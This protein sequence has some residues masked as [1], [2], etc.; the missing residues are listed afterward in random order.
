MAGAERPPRPPSGER[1]TWAVAPDAA[2]VRLDVFLHERFPEVSRS[3]LKRWVEEGR[4]TID[5]RNPKPS[6]MLR[7]GES[8]TMTVPP[9]PPPMPIPQDIPFEIIH[10]D[11]SLLIIHKPAGL[12]VHP[13]AGNESGGTLVNALLSRTERLSREAGDFRPGIVHRLDRE[14][15][16]V[17]VIARDDDAHR[18][19]AAQFKARMVRKEYLALAHDA[20]ATPEGRIDA[21]LGR[22]P[23]DRRR[24]IVR[25][26]SDGKPALTSWRAVGTIGPFAWFRCFPHTGRT[27]QIRVHLKSIGHPIACDHLYG[28]EKKLTLT[29]AHGRKV[30]GAEEPVL[31]RHALHAF[32][33]AFRHPVDGRPV[34]FEAPLPPDLRVL[35]EASKIDRTAL[36]APAIEPRPEDAA[37]LETLPGEPP[38]A[39]PEDSDRGE[40]A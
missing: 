9:P 5:G 7:A 26:D 13:G 1:R 28:R 17:M 37:H 24:H 10:E 25:H 16:G 40:D 30:R 15:S 4:V 23:I 14:T 31:V 18:R 32:R 19:I 6:R 35:R 20:P 22:S 34:S 11:A 21:P 2:G 39:A 12:V 33:L 8:V 36:D 3:A 38:D 27:H 29:E